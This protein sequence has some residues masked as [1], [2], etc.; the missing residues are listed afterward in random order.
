MS[1]LLVHLL[2]DFG[3]DLGVDFEDAWVLLLI[4]FFVYVISH[5]FFLSGYGLATD[6]VIIHQ[7]VDYVILTLRNK[8]ALSVVD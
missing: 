3:A 5:F 2:A 4:H 7:T 8:V 6:V 1:G